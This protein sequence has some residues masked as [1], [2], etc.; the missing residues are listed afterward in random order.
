MNDDLIGR[1]EIVEKISALIKN[2]S[3]GE[4]YCLALDGEWGSGKSFVINMLE[5]KL[6]L[7]NEYFIVKYDAWENSFYSDPL[8]ALLYCILD[9]LQ[10]NFHYIRGAKEYGAAA[11]EIAKNIANTT[12]DIA[13][14]VDPTNK[15]EGVFNVISSIINGIK[16]SIK[17]LKFEKTDNENFKEFKSYKSLLNDVKKILNQLTDYEINRGKQTKLVILVDEIDRCLPDE[18]LK[19]LER[20]HHLLEINNCF[21]VCSLN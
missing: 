5:E 9:G 6:K 20:L 10:E 18:Q 1:N 2:L 17:A 3:K 19:V 12:K 14:A 7:N 8:I 4:H 13:K 11:K 16:N 21:V 15:I